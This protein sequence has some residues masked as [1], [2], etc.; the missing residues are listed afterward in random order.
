[1][2]KIRNGCFRL[3]NMKKSIKCLLLIHNY[4]EV[5]RD[6]PR[7]DNCENIGITCWPSGMI[8]YRCKDC[9]AIKIKGAVC[10]VCGHRQT[11]KYQ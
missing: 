4:K 1:M 10:E 9:G 2:E 7:C 5:E 6:Y 11:L 8:I 3:K